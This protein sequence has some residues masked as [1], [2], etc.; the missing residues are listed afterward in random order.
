[1]AVD[2]VSGRDPLKARARRVDVGILRARA[3][4]RRRDSILVL[5]SGAGASSEQVLGLLSELALEHVALRGD[6]DE[7]P[8]PGSTRTVVL[9]GTNRFSGDE[10]D[11]VRLDAER[12]WVR[13][14]DAAGTPILAIGRGARVLASALGGS[15][16]PLKRGQRGWALVDTRVPHLIAGGP[17]FAWQHERIVL[18]SGAELLAHNRLGPQ[19]F[20]VGRHLGIHFHP[21]ATPER[22][23]AW[24]SPGDD[25]LE[26]HDTLTATR[27]DAAA[28]RYC[29]RRAFSSFL[30]TW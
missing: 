9:V 20:R 6:D 24:R 2:V 28:A 5:A 3:H 18:P 10:I 30:G 8:H 11:R 17:W 23:A 14:A 15:V 12:D 13:R 29:A 27:R 7:L 19:A 26:Y 21:E 25:A 1:M 22:A 4:A 16:E